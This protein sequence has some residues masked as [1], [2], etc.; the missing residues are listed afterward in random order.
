MNAAPPSVSVVVLSYNRPDYLREALDSLRA[1]T[2]ENLSITVIDNPSPASARI[3]SIVGQYA[4]VK[5]I[6]NSANLG[7]AGGMNKGITEAT[8]DFIY[9]TEDDIVLDQNCIR[10]LVEY[11]RENP[12]A[13]LVAPLIYNRTAGTIRCA[14]GDF[15]LGGVYRRRIHGAGEADIGQFARPF[16]VGYID[17]AA[18]F[19][20]QDFWT[21]FNGFRDEYFMYVEAVE[22]CARVRKSGRRMTIVPD[23]KVYHFEPAPERTPPAIEFHKL[24]NFFSLYLLHAPLRVLPEFF[25]RYALWNTLRTILMRR[26]LTGPSLK[27][28]FWTMKEAPALLRERRCCRPSMKLDQEKDW[29]EAVRLSINV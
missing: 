29:E 2:Y 9:L 23:A 3:A 5:L 13:G 6:R 7:Y 20:R 28:L 17:G 10:R 12:S 22:L 15:L 1:Q 26:E 21:S 11:V 27:A 24:K 25:C 16:D 14:G 19:A 8:G 4:D 18:M